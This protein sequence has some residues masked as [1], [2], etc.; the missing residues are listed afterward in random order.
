MADAV[1]KQ[2]GK[3]IDHTPGSAVAAGDVV[4]EG[5][6]VGVA[7]A[8]IAAN[9]LGAICVEGVFEMTKKA[10]LAVTA[11]DVVYW[12]AT[13]GEITKTAADGEECGRAIADAAGADST[14]LVKI[15]L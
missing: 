14:V 2:E 5:S 7:T 4:V 8:A 10:S 15:Q 11:G 3:T 9:T 13:P 6:I 12:D 1:F